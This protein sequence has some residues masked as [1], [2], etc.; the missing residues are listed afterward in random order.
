M[1]KEISLSYFDRF[2]RKITSLRRLKHM[3]KDIIKRRKQSN[4]DSRSTRL[5]LANMVLD[6]RIQELGYNC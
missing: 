6:Q 2:L 3:R 5:I 4:G 1:K